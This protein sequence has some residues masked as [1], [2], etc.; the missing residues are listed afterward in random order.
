QVTNGEDCDDLDAAAHPGAAE[1]CGDS[2][3]EDCDGEA[4]SCRY[5]GDLDPDDADAHL[6][7]EAETSLGY[8]TTF[9]GDMNGDGIGDLAVGMADYAGDGLG[10]F[11]YYGPISGTVEPATV[12]ADITNASD[13]DGVG[14]DLRGIGDQDGDGYDDLVITGGMNKAS[15]AAG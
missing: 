15:A 10:A 8:D 11:L 6:E 12:S 2:V 9:A 4:P 14:F 13:G 1:M 3:D 7:G 5:T